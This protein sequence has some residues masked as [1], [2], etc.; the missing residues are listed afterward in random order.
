MSRSADRV[1]TR[2]VAA[3]ALARLL[4]DAAGMAPDAADVVRERLKLAARLVERTA[5][6]VGPIGYGAAWPQIR[7]E[8]ADLLAQEA[9]EDRDRERQRLTLQPTARMLTQA[10][11]A[12]SWRRYVAGREL[13]VLNVWLRCQAHRRPWQQAAVAAG[14][15]RETA[16]RLL[17]RAFFEIAVGLTRDRRTIE[18]AQR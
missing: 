11:E 18:P 12:L 9:G 17:A 4:H 7:R 8:W 2:R 16:K 1:R 14:Y 6:R 5:G 13:A 10:E 15:A 3:D